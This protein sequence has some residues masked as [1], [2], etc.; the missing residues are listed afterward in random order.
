MLKRIISIIIIFNLFSVS[1]FAQDAAAGG[2]GGQSEMDF[3]K[4]TRNDLLVVFGV[5]AAGAVLGLSTLSFYSEPKSHLKNI[6][7]GGAIGVIIGVGLVAYTQA[8]KSQEVYYEE[9]AL[10]RYAPEDKVKWVS[11]MFSNEPS[12]M[13]FSYTTDF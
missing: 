2:D 8:T 7:V 10:W 1:A 6:L 13:S 9:E 11:D 3:V 4:S 5:G 12:P